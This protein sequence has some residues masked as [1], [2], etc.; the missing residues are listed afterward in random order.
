MKL[1]TNSTT[2]LEAKL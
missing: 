1:S 2:K